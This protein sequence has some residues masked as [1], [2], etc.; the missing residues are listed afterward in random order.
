[1]LSVAI[2]EYKSVRTESLDSMKL[3]NAILSYGVTAIGLI[4]TAGIGLIDKNMLLVAE[5]MFLLF[6]PMIVFFIVVIWAGEVARMYRAGSFLAEHE[7]IINRYVKRSGS[8][9]GW[10]EPALVWENWLLGMS[11]SKK[12]PHQRLYIQHYSVLAM[13]LFLAILS[14]V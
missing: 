5:A 10:D 8:G 7:G 6:I 14:V 12:T 4:F 1:W 13:F 9:D 2:E 11:D 3:Q